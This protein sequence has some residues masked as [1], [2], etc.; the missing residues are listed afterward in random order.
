MTEEDI[1]EVLGRYVKTAVLAKQAG[2]TGVQI[3]AAHGYLLSQF[4][5]QGRHK[6]KRY[7]FTSSCI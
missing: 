6:T 4:F 5:H 3:H 7:S 1:Q 2:F